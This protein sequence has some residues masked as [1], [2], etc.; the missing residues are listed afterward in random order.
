M[1]NKL[2]KQDYLTANAKERLSLTH[3]GE[4]Y[5]NNESSSKK[6]SQRPIIKKLAYFKS[7]TTSIG[8]LPA[9]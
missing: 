6:Q 5:H 4:W 7:A 9:E 2:M 8:S 3:D 1:T